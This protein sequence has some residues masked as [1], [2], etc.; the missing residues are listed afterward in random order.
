MLFSEGLCDDQHDLG[1]SAVAT[2]WIAELWERL[3]QI[4]PLPQGLERLETNPRPFRWNVSLTNS[5]RI[6]DQGSYQD[7]IYNNCIDA[8]FDKPFIATVLVGF[9]FK[10]K[11]ILNYSNK[12]CLF[13]E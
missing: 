3:Q 10:F 7:D 2:P 4:C 13:V 12:L 9:F 6:A 5:D 8:V 11:I 1:T